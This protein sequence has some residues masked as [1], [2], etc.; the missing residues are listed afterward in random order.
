MGV[1]G[2]DAQTH[3]RKRRDAPRNASSPMGW[4]QGSA[5]Y[6]NAMCN[7]TPSRMRG[8]S[9]VSWFMP[10]MLAPLTLIWAAMGWSVVGDRHLR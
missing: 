3:S 10:P 8:A 4:E 7:R 9:S 2:G 5:S 1:S 6:A